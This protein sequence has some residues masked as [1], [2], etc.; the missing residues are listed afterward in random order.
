MS[1]KKSIKKKETTKEFIGKVVNEAISII[2]STLLNAGS[3]EY[4]ILNCIA[5][6]K[7]KKYKVSITIDEVIEVNGKKKPKMTKA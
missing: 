4:K 7:S 3:D 1:K 6:H 2:V 5:E